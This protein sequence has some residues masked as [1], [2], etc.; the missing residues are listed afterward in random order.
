MNEIVQYETED[1]HCPFA[2]W[3]MALESSAAVKVRTAI[4][5][6]EAGNFGDVKPVGGGVPERRIDFGP[7]YRPHFGRDGQKLVILLVGG[8]KKRQHRDIAAAKD[9]WAS[10]KRRQQAGK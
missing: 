3:F 10:Y 5:R 9:F 7:G 8:T 6:M 2:A 4:A 1:G